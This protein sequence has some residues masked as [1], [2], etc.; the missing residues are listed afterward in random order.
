MAQRVK[1]LINDI[2][3]IK[4]DDCKA[5]LKILNAMQI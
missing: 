3:G 2:A 4:W 1:W 5:A